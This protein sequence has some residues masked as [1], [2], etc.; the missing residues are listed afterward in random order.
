MRR[1]G[2]AGSLGSRGPSSAEWWLGVAVAWRPAA[3]YTFQAARRALD[4]SMID[5]IPRF[6]PSIETKCTCARQMLLLAT[7]RCSV[8]QQAAQHCALRARPVHEFG[9]VKK[10]KNSN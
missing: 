8:K 5:S 6:D 10:G 2:A 9:S 3:R 7:R 4:D 1:F